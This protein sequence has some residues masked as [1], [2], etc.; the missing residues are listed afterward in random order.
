[1][2]FEEQHVVFHGRTPSE[3]DLAIQAVAAAKRRKAS[4]MPQPAHIKPGGSNDP[5]RTGR[6]DFD[7]G[8]VWSPP[9]ASD[10]IRKN[11]SDW[12][13]TVRRERLFYGEGKR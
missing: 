3:G 1:M 6:D 8:K 7:S 11:L 12:A 2:N 13:E 5:S 9:T 10:Q 4:T